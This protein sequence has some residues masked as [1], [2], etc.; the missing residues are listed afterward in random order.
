MQLPQQTVES[1][2]ST[3]IGKPEIYYMT[4]PGNGGDSLINIGFFCLADKL[5]LQFK[6]VGPNATLPPNSTL[7]LAGG[8]GLVPEHKTAKDMIE[9]YH[10]TVASM[11]ILPCTARNCDSLLSSLGS[12]TVI[13]FREHYSYAYGSRTCTGGAK[14]YFDHDMA[15]HMDI[16]IVFSEKLPFLPPRRSLYNFIRLI[17]VARLRGISFFTRTLQAYRTDIEAASPKNGSIANDVSKIC[18]FGTIDRRACFYSA[19]AFL[20][21]LSK[22]EEIRTDRLHVAIGAAIL[23]KKVSLRDNSYYKCRAVYESS[24]RGRFDVT[25][26]NSG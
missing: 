24:L 3:L 17:L 4:L 26:A 15:F 25:M 14:A 8:G 9:R 12:N 6:V 2:L 18:S 11:I 16:D 20:G 7:I 22:F 13:F 1:T 10:A 19:R 21:T 5:G 23:K